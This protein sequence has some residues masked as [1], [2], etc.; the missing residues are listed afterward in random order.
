[1]KGESKIKFDS[2]LFFDMDGTLVDTNYANFLSYKRAIELVKKSSFNIPYNPKQR[3]NRSLL[4]NTIPNLT[5]TEFK[6]IVSEKE[7][8]YNDFL[9]ETQL[10]NKIVEI[11]LKYCTSNKT[12]LVTNCREER[13]LAVL[14]YHGLTNKFNALF[15]REFYEDNRKI[16][17]FQNAISKLYILP[18]QVIV[19][20]NEEIEIVDAQNAGILVI[21]P[22]NL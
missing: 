5:E 8:N 9:P 1:M 14:N 21:N 10:N 16:N 22:I 7:K 11:L 2:I 15:F 6:M 20:E 13:A 4:K 17:K 12:V 19:F 3:F 18:Q